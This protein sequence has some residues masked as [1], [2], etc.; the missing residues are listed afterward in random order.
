MRSLVG[1]L[2]V[3][4]P[5]RPRVEDHRAEVRGPGD[6]RDLGHAQLVGVAAR[7]ERDARGLEPLGM[8]L[9]HPLLVDRLALDAVRKSL[10]RAWPLEQRTHDARAYRQVV[11]DQVELGLASLREVDLLGVG[12]AHRA[13][14]DL[15]LDCRGRSHEKT[16][17][18]VS[19]S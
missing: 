6:R 11:V 15:E 17:P 1:M 2:G 5:R 4:P 18:R 3:G 7:R 8:V 12:D 16:L 9:R 14:L 13:S 19:G 10:Q